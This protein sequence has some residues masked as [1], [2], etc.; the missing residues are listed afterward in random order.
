MLN[1]FSI[2]GDLS[3]VNIDNQ[4]AILDVKSGKYILINEVGSFIWEAVNSKEAISFEEIL[5]SI[6]DSYDIDEHKGRIYLQS[7]IEKLIKNEIIIKD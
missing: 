4:T 5:L 2:K 1:G 3:S 6:I 7:F